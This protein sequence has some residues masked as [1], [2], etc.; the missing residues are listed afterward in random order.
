MSVTVVVAS[1]TAA[2]IAAVKFRAVKE[3]E[4]EEQVMD[5]PLQQR[6]VHMMSVGAVD[7]MDLTGVP[8]VAGSLQQLELLQR[9]IDRHDPRS[10]VLDDCGLTTSTLEALVDTL[11]SHRSLTCLSLQRNALDASRYVC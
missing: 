7:P 5:D 9:F 3:E 11:S 1:T 10:I 4:E 8:I 6:L 2:A